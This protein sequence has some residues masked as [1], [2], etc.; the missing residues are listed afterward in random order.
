[1]EIRQGAV[2]IASL[3]PA[4]AAADAFLSCRARLVRN[5]RKR[6]GVLKTRGIHDFLSPWLSD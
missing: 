3:E 2:A 5:G 6:R 4:N 1:V